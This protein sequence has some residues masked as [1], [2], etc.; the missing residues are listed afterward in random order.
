MSDTPVDASK[1]TW[2]I[3]S[4][5]AGAV[6]A[7]FA[8]VPFDVDQ[9]YRPRAPPGQR[10]G[11]RREQECNRNARCSKADLSAGARNLMDRQAELPER[12]GRAQTAEWKV[13][14]NAAA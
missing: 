13:A 3:A 5:C 11:E 4:G 8:A 14:G 7:G 10:P 12:N 2:I 6:G 1:R 9:G